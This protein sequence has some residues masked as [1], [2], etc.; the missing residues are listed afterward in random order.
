MDYCIAGNFRGS[1]LSRICPNIIFMELIFANFIIQPFL[2]HIFHNFA[3]FIFANLKKSRKERKLLA[4]KISSYTVYE[5]SILK[6]TF[7]HT[8]GFCCFW[9]E[10]RCLSR[11]NNFLQ[12]LRRSGVSRVCGEK[13]AAARTEKLDTHTHTQRMTT[14]P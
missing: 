2:H 12:Q 13:V 11:G 8:T 10:E 1:K 9:E 3:N 7:R 5:C 4:S 14:I 6:S